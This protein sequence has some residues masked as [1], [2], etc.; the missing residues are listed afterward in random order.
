MISFI[1]VLGLSILFLFYLNESDFDSDLIRDLF[2]IVG[3]LS[4]LLIIY[5]ISLMV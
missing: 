1:Y 4:L 3:T 2:Y 5:F